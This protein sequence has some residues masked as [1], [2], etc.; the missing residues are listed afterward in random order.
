MNIQPMWAEAR[1][2]LKAFANHNREEYWTF[3][4]AEL[5]KYRD[6]R[7]LMRDS[8]SKDAILESE[9]G[10]EINSARVTKTG[11]ISFACSNYSRYISEEDYALELFNEKQAAAFAL[12]TV[13]VCTTTR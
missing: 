4:F 3:C 10:P 11:N 6:E 8:F 13:Q 1:Q 7:T 5:C 9:S 12:L 2:A